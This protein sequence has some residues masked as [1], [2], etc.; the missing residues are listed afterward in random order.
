MPCYTYIDMFI[1]IYYKENSAIAEPL[2]ESRAVVSENTFSL[3][4]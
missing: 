3:A 4:R 1:G 2:G